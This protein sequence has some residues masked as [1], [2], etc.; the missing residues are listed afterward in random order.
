MLLDTNTAA[1][2]I[3]YETGVRT[4]AD[5][6]ARLARQGMGPRYQKLDGRKRL[7]DVGELKAWAASRL[8]PLVPTRDTPTF[9]RSIA[10]GVH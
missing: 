1:Q 10:G 8:S 2:I 4:T 3:T 5:E 9:P 7:Y 6:L